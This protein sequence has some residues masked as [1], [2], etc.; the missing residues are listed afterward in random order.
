MVGA[1]LRDF[2]FYE[3]MKSLHSTPCID[4]GK[5]QL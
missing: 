1:P 5:N 4:N 2:I 3:T